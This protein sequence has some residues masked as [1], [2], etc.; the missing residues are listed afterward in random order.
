MALKAWWE[1]FPRVSTLQERALR[2]NVAETWEQRL[3]KAALMLVPPALVIAAVV[4]NG[5]Y[6]ALPYDVMPLELH[7]WFRICVV[8]VFP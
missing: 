5:C 3:R 1:H 7:G 2:Q 6:I 8:V 4:L